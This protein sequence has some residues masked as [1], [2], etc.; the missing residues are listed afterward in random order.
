[1]ADL[2]GA[3]PAPPLDALRARLA[4][5]AAAAGLL[6]VAYRSLDTAL[7]TLLV[8]ATPAGLVS[9]TFDGAHPGQTLDRLAAEL[10]PRVLEAPARL[11]DAARRLERLIA[12]RARA[13]DGPLDLSLARGF[14]RE[15]VERLREIPYGETRSYAEVAAAV[16]SPR[17]VR[18]V[19]TAC[20]RNP[21]PI[22]IPCHR[23]V[24]SDGSLG[25][26][27]GGTEAKRLLLGVEAAR[28]G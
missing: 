12:G 11:D 23:V 21:L 14:G 3:L 5:R 17:A 22:A 13:F 15:V 24:R 8:A 28:R 20:R 25:Q 7:G 9:V 2:P 19:G 4:E 27:A 10:S 6:D 16:G 1:M 26:Y 18:A